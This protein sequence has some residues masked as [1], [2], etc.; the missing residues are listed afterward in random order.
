MPETT[1]PTQPTAPTGTAGVAAWYLKFFSGMTA[2]RLLVLILLTGVCWLAW[3]GREDWQ[4]QRQEQTETLRDLRREGDS[5]DEKA[6]SHITEIVNLCNKNSNDQDKQRRAEASVHMR[7]ATDVMNGQKQALTE[8]KSELSG[9]KGELSSL[10]I[11]IDRL[12][13]KVGGGINP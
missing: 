11:S 9:L 3:T 2:D 8:L 10:R 6:R 5:R 7:E 12:E 4:L 13:K 1:D